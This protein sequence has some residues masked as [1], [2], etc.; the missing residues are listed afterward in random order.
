MVVLLT[1]LS[2]N[3]EAR[4]SVPLLKVLWLIQVL[5]VSPA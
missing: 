2:T 5:G 3:R 1:C 4:L